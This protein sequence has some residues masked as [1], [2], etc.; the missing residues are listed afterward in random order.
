MISHVNMP[1]VV[2]E[3]NDSLF[4]KI[5]EKT[6][7]SE[8]DRNT[9]LGVCKMTVI[10]DYVFKNEGVFGNKYLQGYFF[11]SEFLATLVSN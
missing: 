1:L 8:P 4:N 7:R 11:I 6:D 5:T 10:I 2:C 3:S 9:I